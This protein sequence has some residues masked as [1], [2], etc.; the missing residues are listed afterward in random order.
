MRG[1]L[2]LTMHKTQFAFWTFMGLSIAGFLFTRDLHAQP[3]ASPQPTAGYDAQYHPTDHTPQSEYFPYKPTP[4]PSPNPT[5]SGTSPQFSFPQ[6]G[7]SPSPIHSPILEEE[8]EEVPKKIDLSQFPATA[9]DEVVVPLPSEIFNV[10]DKVGT[11]NWREELPASLGKSTGDRAQIALLLGAVIANGFIAVE[12]E[13]P[14]KVKEIGREVLN[15]AS[16]INVRKAVIGRSKSITDKADAKDWQ[17]ARREFDGALQDVRTAMQELD[18]NDLAQLVSLGGWLRGTEVL[19]SVAKKTYDPQVAELLHQPEL[20]NYF[21][22]RIDSMPRRLKRSDY[23]DNIRNVL[24][25]I[26]PIVIRGNNQTIPKE[27]VETINSLTH[28][29]VSLFTA[30]K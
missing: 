27:D 6:P 28:K 13:D 14:E 2:F 15:L 30:P 10:L 20:I 8:T 12:L 19:T 29:V 3:V 7:G 24:L 16:A 11:P 4:S 23:V 26:R 21:L 18:D 1:T 5:P 25:Q 9:V 22:R 17:G